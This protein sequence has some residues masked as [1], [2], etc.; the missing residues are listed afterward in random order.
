MNAAEDQRRP[1]RVDR[2]GGTSSGISDTASGCNSRHSRSS[3]ACVMPVPTLAGINQPALRIVIAEQQR[4][5]PVGYYF[6]GGPRS[7]RRE[8]DDPGARTTAA[9]SGGGSVDF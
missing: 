5:E 7:F 2:G 9:A 6:A 4:A 1:N 8:S 3:S